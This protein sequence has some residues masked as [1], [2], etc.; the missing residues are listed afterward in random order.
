MTTN[1]IDW[2]KARRSGIGGSDVAAILGLNKYK[3]ALD[4]YN[5]KISTE[6]P[7]DQQTEAAYFGSILEDVVAKEFSKR[8]GLKVQRV[9]TM[10]RSG[11]GDWMIANIDRAVV[12]PDIAGRVSVYDEQRQAETGRM[13]STNW[14]LEC[15]TANQFMADMW[16][17]SQEPEI[18]SGKVVT[19]HK[20]PIYYETQVQW[21]L[22]VT[23]CELCYVA[24]LLGGQDFRIYAVKRDE[25]VIK[26]LKEYCS[27]F[28]HENVL[29]RIPPQAQ[30]MEDVQKLFP[31]DNG[32]MV[33]ATN[34][35]AADI[36]E[37]RTLA[38]RI[39][40]LTDQQT[41]VKSRLIA[42]LGANSGLMIGGE[43]ACTYKAQKSTRFDSTRFKKEQPEVYQDYVKS[44]ETR[45]F[46][47]A[48]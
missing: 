42:S 21:Y 31:V 48:A 37:L 13:I 9:N 34:E 8:T 17:E 36:G 33:E 38:E 23:G 5:D 20:I 1:R 11:K 15:K 16:G 12:N 41:V 2:L 3:S 29:N 46:R 25:D 4:I 43:K 19:E 14:I 7:K 47:L 45:V 27:I 26:A 30:N 44:T 39:K 10:L 32:D 28:W 35:Q 24:V 6:E 18:V 22:A 40:E